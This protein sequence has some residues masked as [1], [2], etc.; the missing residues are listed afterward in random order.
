MPFFISQEMIDEVKERSD[1]VDTISEHVKLKKNGGSHKGLCPFHSEKTPSFVVSGE[2]KVYHCFGCGA[3]GDIF[4]FL[5]KKENMSYPHA[6]RFVAKRYGVELHSKV[7]D[8]A[9]VDVNEPLYKI[10]QIASEYYTSKLTDDAARDARNYLKD[11]GLTDE[12][13]KEFKIGYA[14]DLWQGLLDFL[15][16]KKCSLDAAE[17]V[18]LII[19]KNGRHYDRFRNRIIFPI[20]CGKGRVIG[21]GGRVLMNGNMGD[22]VKY[23]NSPESEI[24]K[25]EKVFYGIPQ[26][27]SAI[28]KQGRV[29]IVEGYFD[30]ISLHQYG[31]KNAVAIMG[32]ALTKEH[33]K[34]VVRYAKE[35]CVV[36]DADDAGKRAVLKSAPLFLASGIKVRFVPMPKDTDPHDFL[37]RYGRVEMERCITATVPLDDMI[38]ASLIYRGGD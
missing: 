36:F 16:G 1:I 15:K 32:T 21:F 37:K 30:M 34:T 14:P 4:S 29:F 23:I 35:T 20:L 19:K 3:G 33:L 10:N 27:M 28:K 5:I 26:A 31:F 38:I 7:D 17:K 8:Y 2:K 11:R 25:K 9:A 24:F 12:I 6:I 18:G 22:D 13:I